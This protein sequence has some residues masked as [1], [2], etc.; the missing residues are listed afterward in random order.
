MNT[1]PAIPEA[2]LQ[3]LPA[4]LLRAARRRLRAGQVEAVEA[5]PADGMLAVTGRVAGCDGETLRCW[6][7]IGD[8]E[9]EADCSCGAEAVCEHVAAVLLA[10]SGRPEG[11]QAPERGRSNAPEPGR[12]A[13]HAESAAPE[14]VVVLA[15]GGH[16]DPGAGPAVE[17]GAVFRACL[18]GQ[19]I[20][21]PYW[22]VRAREPHQP[23]FVGADQRRFL[24]RALDDGKPVADGR[25]VRL[26]PGVDWLVEMLE[27]LA[28]RFGSPGG[29]R[30]RVVGA[31][32]VPAAWRARAD[33]A[34]RLEL[35]AGRSL[36]DGCAVLPGCPPLQVDRQSGDCHRLY[37]D[38]LSPAVSDRLLARG[39]VAPEAVEA[40]GT[41]L[42]AHP[43]QDGRLLPAARRVIEIDDQRPNPVLELTGDADTGQAWAGLAFRYGPACF[44]FGSPCDSA[45]LDE[46]GAVARVRRDPEAE[47]ECLE[48]LSG[49]GLE[50]LEDAPCDPSA[51]GGRLGLRRARRPEE[52]WVRLQQTMP[53][54]RRAGW[55]LR[56]R[57]AFPYRLVEPDGWYGC[58]ERSGSAAF[59]LDLGVELEGRRVSL[60]DALLDWL[61]QVP[62]GGLKRLLDDE[63]GD[64]GVLLRLDA[65]RLVVLPARR[66]RATLTGLVE[67]AGGGA[68][69]DGRLRLPLAR[70][71]GC[72]GLDRDFTLEGAPELV[73]ALRRLGQ[74]EAPEAGRVPDGF[75]AELRPYQRRG[76]GWLQMLA[77]SGFGGVLADD[78]GLGKTLQTLAHLL[79][80]KQ[81]GRMVR[82]CLVVAPAGLLFNWRAE[83]ARFAPGLRVLTLHGPERK[84][85]FHRIAS[86]DLVLTSYALLVRDQR[87]L[88]ARDWHVVVLDE[89]QAIKNPASA[90]ARAA[91]ALTAR[92][93]IALSGTPLEN[94]LGELWS[95]FRFV[96]PGLLGSRKGFDRAFRKPIEHSADPVRLK[97]LRHRIAPFLLRRTKA[98]VTPELPPV[99][100]IERTVALAPEQRRVYE[101]V[102]LA[103]HDKVRRAL[104]H[105]APGQRRVLV[106]D[107]LLRLR[108][109]CCDPRLVDPAGASAG[110]AKLTELLEMLVRLHD[111]GRQVLVFSQ[112]TSMLSLIETELQQMGL[113]YEKLTGRTRDRERPVA[114]FQRGQAGVFLISLKAGGA[115]LNL[116][117]AD[118]VIHYD[119]WW[120]PAAE[121]QATGR[122]HRIGQ[123]RQVFSWRLVTAGT[124]EERV[125]ELQRRKRELVEGLLSG[126]GSLRLEHDDIEML[127]A[128][129][130]AAP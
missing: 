122:A 86:A 36:P 107:A 124:V 25:W 10:A 41:E 121:D 29:P 56:R 47:H 64:D 113:G 22:P 2:L 72:A 57:P 115:G 79:A 49:L 31:R 61:D 97:V 14:L 24:L 82:P 3:A 34:Q 58:L 130:G 1:P 116:T 17:L 33:G 38:G 13:P 20:E 120:N 68:R 128:P 99:V 73:G 106:L 55:E 11:Q 118:A 102:R 39:W 109:V 93:R 62:P 63:A 45:L 5:L 32:A 77:E 126:A 28:C 96:A 129:A 6:A 127:F 43:D 85:R 75:R 40:V 19:W 110:S 42:A 60:L 111:E 88:V 46:K 51:S 100:D 76:L 30:L 18:D 103:M 4:A 89:A 48:R 92:Q 80:E 95:L 59:E 23:R 21:R 26:A 119:P 78:M 27:T 123:T 101:S 69:H 12:P 105:A 50:P 74:G 108:Q 83:A 52:A 15:L 84:R 91:R 66:L 70:L 16:G 112:F 65:T 8:G 7:G 81:A 53:S 104:E 114:R 90:T 98:E 44:A 37:A 35:G 71:G 9:L 87:R 125:L 94:H 67:W 54:L 117:A